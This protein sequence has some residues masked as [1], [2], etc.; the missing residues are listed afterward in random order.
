MTN[1]RKLLPIEQEAKYAAQIFDLTGQGYTQ[2]E[3][4]RIMGISAIRVRRIL[5]RVANRKPEADL[6]H[7]RRVQLLNLE[8]AKQAV[9]S[10]LEA[11]HVV[12]SNGVVVREDV[13]DDDGNVIW[14]PVLGP[15]GEQVTDADGRPRYER[16]KVALTDHSAV[17]EAVA[18]MR[19]IEDSIMKLLGTQQPVK[20]QVEL[21][22]VAYEIKGVD[23]SKVT[24]ANRTG[25]TSSEGKT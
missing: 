8:R 2:A 15:R 3:T 23:M 7:W 13:L 17:L 4:A 25:D 19:K 21:Q 20:Q 22:H 12:V 9:L 24:G 16:R 6:A 14:D 10:V 1:G 5:E 18:E 11:H